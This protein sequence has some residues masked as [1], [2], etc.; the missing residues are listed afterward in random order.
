LFLNVLLNVH[1]LENFV[2][3]HSS[4]SKVSLQPP[5]AKAGV[6]GVQRLVGIVETQKRPKSH[7]ISNDK[8]FNW[9][10]A[11]RSG[12]GCCAAEFDVFI[13]LID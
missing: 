11:L 5:T 13:Y 10:I 2:R 8:R 3:E 9:K 12:N 6:G 7:P 1:E 4:Y